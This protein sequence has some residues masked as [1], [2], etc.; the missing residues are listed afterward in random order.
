MSWEA[1]AWAMNRAP[2]TDPGQKLVL[3]ALAELAADDGTGAWPSQDSLAVKALCSVRTVRRHLAALE[4]AGLIRRGD[5]RCVDHLPANRR[6]VVYDLRLDLARST[7]PPGHVWPVTGDRSEDARADMERTSGRSPVTGEPPEEP[8]R[9]ARAG[10]GAHVTPARE[11]NPRR[12]WKHQDVTDPPACG[13]CREARL[14]AEQAEARARDN[15]QRTE[16][17]EQLRQSQAYRREVER[18]DLCDMRGYLPSGAVCRHDKDAPRRAKRG[19]A[20]C[21]DAL[22]AGAQ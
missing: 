20:A 8:P 15:R 1:T 18:C 2:V 7:C 3:L 19:A 17:V 22:R 9:G 5:Q 16:H 6:P 13:G 4:H 11:G 10:T 21:R 14:A 12:C